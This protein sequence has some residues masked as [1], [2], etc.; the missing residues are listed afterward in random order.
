MRTRRKKTN[1]SQTITLSFAEADAIVRAYM[2]DRFDSHAAG[3]VV[4]K[5]VEMRM[6]QMKEGTYVWP[7]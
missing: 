5:V 6:Q 3:S 1:A 2:G 7:E 4:A